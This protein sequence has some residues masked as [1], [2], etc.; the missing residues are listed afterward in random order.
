MNASTG[1]TRLARLK[2][3]GRRAATKLEILKLRAEKDIAANGLSFRRMAQKYPIAIF[4]HVYGKETVM[5]RL[6]GVKF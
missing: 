4:V 1:R 2:K 3:A 6:K 5:R